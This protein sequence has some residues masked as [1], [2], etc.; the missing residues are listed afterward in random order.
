M[1]RNNFLSYSDPSSLILR[2]VENHE[3]VFYSFSGERF[4][5]MVKLDWSNSLEEVDNCTSMFSV[6]GTLCLYSGDNGNIVLWNPVS[7]TIKDLP[8]SEVQLAQFDMPYG[9]D[10]YVDFDVDYY[11]HGFGY[12]HVTNDYKVIWYADIH[13]ELLTRYL[14]DEENLLVDWLESIDFNSVWEIYSLRSNSWRKLHVDMP[15]SSKCYECTQV[16]MDGVCHWLCEYHQTVGPC[17]VSFYL[18]NEVFF[19]T[20]IPSDVDDCFYRKAS[21][22]NLAVLNG[23]ITL[24]SYH[25]KTTTFHISILGEIGMEESWTKLLIVGPLSSVMRPIGVGV[26]GEIVF[27]RKDQKLVWLDLH[28]Q[29]TAELGY[30]G[31]AVHSSQII[32]YK[33]SILPIEGISN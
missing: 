27:I 30:Q 8:N 18:S 5:N 9:A 25:E 11:L 26:K 19:I 22:I 33:E 24:I 29:M 17:L 20:P 7:Q 28:T 10:E 2:V 4:K 32:I 6:N 31:G 21:W 16:Y 14:E 13:T 23:F 12:D 3:T 1:F 15:Y